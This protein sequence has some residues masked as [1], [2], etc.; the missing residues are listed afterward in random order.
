MDKMEKLQKDRDFAFEMAKSFH[1]ESYLQDSV[2][3][4][5]D[6]VTRLR[7]FFF[8]RLK[9][10]VASKLSVIEAYY[11]ASNQLDDQ[12]DC[13]YIFEFMQTLECAIS[14]FLN[15]YKCEEVDPTEPD[16]E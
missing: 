12:D 5:E 13:I 11:T 10:D 1:C 8:D 16:V 4:K 6:Q 14:N 9:R 2:P 7:S 15:H 3:S